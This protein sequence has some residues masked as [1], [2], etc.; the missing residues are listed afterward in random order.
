VSD[1]AC[2]PSVAAL[3]RVAALGWRPLESAW[4]GGWLLRAAG[5][6]TGRANSTLPLGDPGSPL[7]V[8][9]DHVEHWYGGRDL[10]PRFL[11]PTPT[12]DAEALDAELDRR[13]WAYGERVRVLV[14]PVVGRA[15][16]PLAPDLTVVV[17]GEPDDAWV[18]AYHY[19]GTPLPPQAR[20]VLAGGVELGFVSVREL[21]TERVLAIAR[22]S[23]DRD[24]SGA[25]WLGVTAVE[26]APAARG[27]GLGR[28]VMAAVL[29][30]GRGRGAECCYLQVSEENAPALAMYDRLG[31]AEHHR[32]HYRLAP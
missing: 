3:E 7:P 2:D 22:G 26:V 10:A 5:G 14:A 13:G 20:A 12:P 29:D 8:A 9:V 16:A 15:L 21:A 30:W 17:D 11:L 27:R 32:Y 4:L 23:V 31:F 28:A 1:S 24:E 6:F 18:A 19:R 25:A